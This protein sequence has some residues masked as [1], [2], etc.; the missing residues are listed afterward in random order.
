MQFLNDVSFIKSKKA[1]QINL[2][3]REKKT[4]T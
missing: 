3:C 4:P 1:M 2:A